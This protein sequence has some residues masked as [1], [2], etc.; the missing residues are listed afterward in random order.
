MSQKLNLYEK[1]REVLG[2]TSSETPYVIS[3]SERYCSRAQIDRKLLELDSTLRIT[4]KIMRDNLK[5]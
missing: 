4:A 2:T 1:M 5:R 3:L